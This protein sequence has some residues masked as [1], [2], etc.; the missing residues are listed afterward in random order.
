M[1]RIKVSEETAGILEIIRGHL[2]IR[3]KKRMTNDEIIKD[4]LLDY[5][6]KNNIP[7]RIPQ[8]KL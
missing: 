1:V 6:K 7:L 3:N 2:T 4:A 8:G 5:A